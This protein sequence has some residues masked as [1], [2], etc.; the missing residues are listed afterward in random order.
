MTSTD[1]AHSRPS[2]TSDD[3]VV[4]AGKLTEA[5]ERLE[6]ARGAL[7]TFHQLIGS[8]D[9][10]LDEVV[11]LLRGTGH[12]ALAD[13]ITEELLG[14]NVLAGRWTFQL[15]EE[16]EDGYCACWRKWERAALDELTAGRRHVYEAELKAARRTPGRAGH[17]ATP[18]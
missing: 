13:G 9:E 3:E 12:D 7:Y 10:Q 17:E 8:A 4:A 1:E 2:G 14:R 11:E 5:L 16:F 6:R 18:A 15:L